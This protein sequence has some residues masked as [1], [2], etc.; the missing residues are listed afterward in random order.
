MINVNFTPP[1]SVRRVGDARWRRFVIRDGGGHF[2]T[3][4]A[5]SNDPAE[6]MLFLRESEAMRAGLGV[7]EIDGATETFATSITV[8]VT[9]D[10]WKVKD[11]VAFLKR[12]ARLLVL[13]NQESRT[14][15]IEID[16]DGLKEQDG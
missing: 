4:Q 12:W 10:A 9:T 5:W 3:G 2:W 16:W 14:V 7:H 15:K 6:A 1:I 11:L 8:S 13:K